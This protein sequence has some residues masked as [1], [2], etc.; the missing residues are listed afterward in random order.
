VV[1]QCSI[2][3]YSTSSTILQMND[4]WSAAPG[5]DSLQLNRVRPCRSQI[6]LNEISMGFPT[7]LEEVFTSE[8][9]THEKF[10]NCVIHPFIHLKIIL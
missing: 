3:V 2:G 10:L 7:H 4:I 8:I 1:C 5:R 6:M 9:M